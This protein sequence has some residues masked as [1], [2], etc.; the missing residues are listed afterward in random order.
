MTTQHADRQVLAT[1]TLSRCLHPSAPSPPHELCQ[2]GSISQSSAG[3]RLRQLSPT[4]N[5]LFTFTIS[6]L[7]P[8]E[9]FSKRCDGVRPICGQCDR[10]NRPDDCEYT[11]G[12]G[13]S[14]T[15]ILEE[16]I[17][18]L[19]ARIQELE[20]PADS[21]TPIVL[22]QP[23]IQSEQ[24]HQAPAVENDQRDGVSLSESLTGSFTP[25]FMPASGISL[26]STLARTFSH[27]Q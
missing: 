22:H 5:G 19:E 17:S 16:N 2:L 8:A 7:L 25:T 26:L 21:M 24:Q 18:R 13:R 3:S 6:T 20:N 23:Y 1:A 14:R 11:D 27:I 4:Q 10:A 15:Q 12:Q 9:Q